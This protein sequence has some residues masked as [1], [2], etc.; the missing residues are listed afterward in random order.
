MQ[1]TT[2]ESP[3]T[4]L[5]DFSHPTAQEIRRLIVKASH[6]FKLIE[7]NDKIMVCV[8]GGKDS[9][10]L[11][12]LMTEI[13]RRV[14][15]DFHF[16]AVC[17]DQKQPGFDSEAFEK[18]VR[19]LGVKLTILERD[20][21]S[22][23]TEK[24]K[25]GVYCSLCSRLRRAILY[26]YAFENGFNKMALGHHREDLLETL[27]L[28]LFYSGHVASMP[29]RLRSDDQRNIVIR[30]LCYVPEQKL[31][32]LQAAWKFPVIPCNLCGSQEGLKRKKIKKLLIDLEKDFPNIKSSLLTSLGNIRPSQMLDQS[33][34]DFQGFKSIVKDEEI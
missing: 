1:L 11:I 24:V 29:P 9:S 22:I 19:D 13:K 14:E 30:P 31:L 33:V 25:D 26:D 21:Y 3:T 10:I 27:M 8:S 34:W 16:E 17:L 4:N 23:V 32:E 20:T 2:A 15:F 7:P 28:N 6:D 18:W 12:A 5:P